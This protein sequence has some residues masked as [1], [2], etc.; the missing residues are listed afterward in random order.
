MS[1]G[2][3]AIGGALIG[4]ITTG[5]ISYLLLRR[6]NF[7]EK[8][9]FLLKNKSAENVKNLLTKMLGHKSY[10]DR[11]FDALCKPIGGYSDDEI[12]QFL[13]E[14]GA[15]KFRRNNGAVEWWYLESRQKDRIAKRKVRA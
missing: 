9:M 3:W 15:R 14:V 5:A 11:S 2:W 1:E 7:H 13:H 4:A 6:Q 12:R 10:I 8:E